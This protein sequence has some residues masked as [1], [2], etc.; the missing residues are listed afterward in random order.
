MLRDKSHNV[1]KTSSHAAYTLEALEA[2]ETD[3]R[4]LESYNS[5]HFTSEGSNGTRLPRVARLT[6][7]YFI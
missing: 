5:N 2:K 6:S 3:E 1:Q 7:P 4:G